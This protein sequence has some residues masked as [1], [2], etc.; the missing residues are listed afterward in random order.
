MLLVL[1]QAACALK[2]VCRY[3]PKMEWL[4]L[5]LVV[6]LGD[7]LPLVVVSRRAV[8]DRAARVV[9]TRQLLGDV[10]RR[11]AEQSGT[12]PVVHERRTQRD[13]PATVARR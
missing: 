8:G 3:R 9:D 2:S 1:G 11:R 13:L 7:S 12:E 6:D 10:E 5:Q 4:A